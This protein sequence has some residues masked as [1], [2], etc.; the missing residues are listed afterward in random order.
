MGMIKILE[1]RERAKNELGSAYDIREFH[2]AVIGAGS[3]PLQLLERQVER[4]I[5]SKR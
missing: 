2:D 4:Y 3:L 1:L 5:S